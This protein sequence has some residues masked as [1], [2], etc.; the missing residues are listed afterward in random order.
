MMK[1]L[2]LLALALVATTLAACGDAEDSPDRSVT[3][4]ADPNVQ[5]SPQLRLEV[6]PDGDTAYT[7]DAAVASAGN[8]AFVLENPQS[9]RHD[10]VIEN[11][12]GG[13]LGRTE[14]I[15]SGT[16]SVTITMEPGSYTFFCSVP[17]H[18]EE[19]MEGTLTVKPPPGG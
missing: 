7:A 13:T 3:V 16:S 10:V 19:G 18:R 1:P 15:G 11:A 17:G 8:V 2:H 12:K 4:T 14:V 6:D 5:G 9:D